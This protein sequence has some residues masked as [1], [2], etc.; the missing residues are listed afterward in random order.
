M[1]NLFLI[2]TDKPSRLVRIYSDSERN[3]FT[4]K[5]EAEVNDSFKEY[6]NIY[7]TSDE[8]IKDCWV[9]NTKRNEFY[10][11]EDYLGIQPNLKKIILTTDPDLIAD[12][13]QAIDDD[14][15][16]WFVKNPTCEFVEVNSYHIK[17]D[18]SGKLHY[19]I[20]IPQEEPKPFELPKALPDDIFYQSLGT[21]QETI[22]EHLNAKLEFIHEASR[23]MDF[24]LGFKTGG[25]IGANYQA[26]RMYSEEDF[27]L[28]ARQYYREIKLDK[29][30]LLWDDLA[31]KCLE[32]F[33]KK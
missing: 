25:I 31:D 17:G 30:N 16:E 18:V 32:Q 1:Q 9:L 19:K 26:E 22:E 20:I 14:F 5:L 24:D 27:K 3:N 2:L 23:N 12:G 10:F 21:K 28:F 13:I 4:L 15:L 11:C 8:E 7:I 6:L 33:K 29:S